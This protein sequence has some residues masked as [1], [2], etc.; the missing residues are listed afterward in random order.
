MATEVKGGKRITVTV[1]V[2][3]LALAAQAHGG[4]TASVVRSLKVSNYLDRALREGKTLM[5]RDQ[6]GTVTEVEFV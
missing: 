2:E 3:D 4:T 1:P 6:D 5:L